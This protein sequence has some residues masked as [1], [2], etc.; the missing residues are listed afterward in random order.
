VQR[1]TEKASA[2]TGSS[3]KVQPHPHHRPDDLALKA[4]VI[5]TVKCILKPFF[6]RSVIDKNDFKLVARAVTA[7][8]LEKH[9]GREGP[10][11]TEEQRKGELRESVDK[12]LRAWGKIK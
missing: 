9:E 6:A 12:V 4:G 11:Q 3:R 2:S 7:K 1:R 10:A 8:Y 5:K